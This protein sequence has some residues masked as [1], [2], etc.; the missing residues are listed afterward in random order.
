[1]ACLGWTASGQPKHA[2]RLPADTPLQTLTAGAHPNFVDVDAR[3]NQLLAD[4]SDQGA[5][6]LYCSKATE[7]QHD[8]ITPTPCR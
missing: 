5:G 6:M 1:V 7:P 8:S 2:V 4:T 3:W